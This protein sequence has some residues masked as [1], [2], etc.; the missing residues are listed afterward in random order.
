VDLELTDSQAALRDSFA[1]FFARE[2]SPD[3]VRAAEPLGFDAFLWR[4]LVGLGIPSMGVAEELGGL[5]AEMLDAALV[6]EV[7]GRHL[8]PVP[9]AEATV[10]ARLVAGGATGDLRRAVLDGSRLATVVLD[11]G[12]RGDGLS[13]VP[14]GAVADVVVWLD[15]DQLVASEV[16]ED[17]PRPAPANLGAS[18]LS[19]ADLSRPGWLAACRRHVL[20]VGEEAR[21]AHRR[22]TDEW[23]ALT[24]AALAGLARGAL[25][26]GVD[27]AKARRQ[28]GVAIGAFQ[29]V[30]HRLADVATAVEG[31]RWLAYEAAWAQSEDPGRASALA[32]MAML[33]SAAS[34]EQAA[35]ASLHFHGGYGF[36]LEYDIQLYFRR[37]KGWALVN[38]D[39]GREYRRLAALLFGTEGG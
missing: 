26:L 34:A 3:R 28:F 20:A 10:A 1:S 23:R 21:A 8:A 24:A 38:G 19:V 31:A 4:R 6:V 17:S 35:S 36:M 39:P 25:D 22:A 14:A 9:L 11:H 30:Q 15:G 7:A 13:V 29:A 18:P 32:S 27:Y 2:S 16:D 37:A 33:F 12:G 5:G